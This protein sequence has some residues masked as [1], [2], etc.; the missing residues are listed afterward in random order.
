MSFFTPILSCSF[1]SFFFLSLLNLHCSIKTFYL[2][3]YIKIF[4][5]QLSFLRFLF[6]SNVIPQIFWHLF[7]IIILFI[8]V[9]VLYMYLLLF[10]FLSQHDVLLPQQTF[11][12]SQNLWEL[13]SHVTH[14]KIHFKYVA[15][16]LISFFTKEFSLQKVILK[17]HLKLPT[18]P[19]KNKL[20]LQNLHK[21]L[22]QY[23]HMCTRTQ[24]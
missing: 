15:D 2:V 10:Y 17:F 19:S 16:I 18:F 11:F 4:S 23:T 8:L 7:F 14:P 22:E 13:L 12:V 9:V 1:F 6:L 24:L 21:K 20:S 3:M 5:S